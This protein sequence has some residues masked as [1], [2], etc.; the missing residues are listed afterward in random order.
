MRALVVG[1]GKMGIPIAYALGKFGFDVV[2]TDVFE[3]KLQDAKEKLSTVEIISQPALLLRSTKFD[4]CISAA[5]FNANPVWANWCK[6]RQIPYCDLGGNQAVSETIQQRSRALNP[7]IPV[8]TDLGLA[9]G[10]VNILAEQVYREQSKRDIVEEIRLRV[11][12]LPISILDTKLKYAQVFSA[13]GLLNEYSGI[14]QTIKNGEQFG[15]QALGG[16]KPF[17][18]GKKTYEVFYTS[19]GLAS[20]LDLM[21]A[22]GVKNVDYKTIRNPGHCAHIR[23]LLEECGISKETFYEIINKACPPTDKDQVLIYA[24]AV[25]TESSVV[26]QYSIL[27]HD[28]WTAMQSCTAFPAAAVAAIM[29]EKTWNKPVLDYSDVPFDSFCEKLDVLDFIDFSTSEVI[30]IYS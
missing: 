14:C 9:P 16:L 23:F 20:T 18:M 2:V 13:E 28:G 10:L 11:G 26:K 21:L 27:H 6:E 12:G 1:A 7:H 25:G 17:I 30:D 22:R 3:S 15:V 19:G 29:A 4:V 8:F 24:S 5:T